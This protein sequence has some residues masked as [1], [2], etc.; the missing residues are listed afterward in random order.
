MKL[1]VK[2]ITFSFGIVC[3]IYML[4]LGWVA[5]GGW[6]SDIVKIISSFYIGFKPTFV[7]GIIGGIWGFFDGAIFGLILGFL[8]NALS[9][10]S[11]D[12][13]DIKISIIETFENDI[14]SGLFV[15]CLLKEL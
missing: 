8:Y 7:G 5:Y 2:A 15:N 14:C 9:F 12:F 10:L 6:G 3:G 13:E 4:F 1:N 11:T